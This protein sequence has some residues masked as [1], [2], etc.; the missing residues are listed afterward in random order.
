VY[1]VYVGSTVTVPFG[2]GAAQVP[3]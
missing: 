3:V 1:I 2:P